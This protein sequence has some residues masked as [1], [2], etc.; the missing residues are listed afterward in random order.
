MA[1]RQAR[2]Q[3]VLR[4]WFAGIAA[5]RGIVRALDRLLA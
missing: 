4:V 2:E 3:Q 1:G 5:E